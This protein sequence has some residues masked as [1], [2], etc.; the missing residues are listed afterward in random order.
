MQDQISTI[1]VVAAVI[2]DAD[3]IFATQRGYGDF[4]DMWEFPGG[5]MDEDPAVAYGFVLYPDVGPVADC[6]QLF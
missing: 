3:R 5:K 2:R 6:L 1:E 4:K